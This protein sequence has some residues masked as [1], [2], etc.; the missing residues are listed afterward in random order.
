MS[1]PLAMFL[2][3]KD[4]LQRYLVQVIDQSGDKVFIS[5]NPPIPNENFLNGAWGLYTT[6]TPATGNDFVLSIVISEGSSPGINFFKSVMVQD[7]TGVIQ[8]FNTATASYQFVDE[9]VGGLFDQALW[10]WGTGTNKVWTT[11]HAERQLIIV[12]N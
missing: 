8:T 3:N 5:N 9:A 6:G 12:P 7:S 1:G 2:G 11:T 10:G 4:R